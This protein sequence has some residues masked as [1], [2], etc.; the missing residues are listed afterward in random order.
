MVAAAL[1]LL[2]GPRHFCPQEGLGGQHTAACD[3]GKF[4]V[5]PGAFLQN[6]VGNTS[7]L[8]SHTDVDGPERALCAE[9]VEWAIPGELAPK[10]SSWERKT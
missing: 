4:T 10:A 3:N 8:R 6:K 5:G 1:A 2:E 7:V 9:P